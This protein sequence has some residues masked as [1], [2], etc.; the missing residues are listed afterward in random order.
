M[1]L[2]RFGIGF[3]LCLVGDADLLPAPGRSA[4]PEEEAL[5]SGISYKETFTTIVRFAAPPHRVRLPAALPGLRRDT[6]RGTRFCKNSSAKWRPQGAVLSQLGSGGTS[7]GR[8]LRADSVWISKAAEGRSTSGRRSPAP[9]GT[10]APPRRWRVLR[11]P[12]W[13][14]QGLRRTTRG[15]GISPGLRD[16]KNRVERRWEQSTRADCYTRRSE[17]LKSGLSRTTSCYRVATWKPRSC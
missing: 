13:C 7:W 14:R 2:S 12:S 9:R 1:G 3:S 17:R 15:R 6:W 10:K 5:E 11:V 4:A 16:R 8:A